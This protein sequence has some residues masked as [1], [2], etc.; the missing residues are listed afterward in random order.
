MASDIRDQVHI[1]YQTYGH[2][3]KD[4][5]CHATSEDGIH[6]THDPTNPIYR[7]T[8]M[9]W[10]AGRAIDAEVYID[11]AKSKAYLYFAT[12]DPSMQRQMLGLAQ[13]DL[14]SNFDAGSW[15]VITTKGASNQFQ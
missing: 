10:S 11:R 7:P 8:Y 14:N 5:I 13:T 4:A 15:K 9:P 6:F 1:F 2:G 3:A 12:R